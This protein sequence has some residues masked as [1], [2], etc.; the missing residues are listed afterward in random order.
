MMGTCLTPV[1][2]TTRYASACS[3]A[4][5]SWRQKGSAAT[6]RQGY[7]RLNFL[8][9]ARANKGT[10]VARARVVRQGRRVGVCDVDV[11]QAAIIVAKGLF[12]Y[13]FLEAKA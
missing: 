2:R 10:L 11:E 9:P 6:I 1:R 12:T 7:K 13:L 5:L 3:P 4:Y 8:S